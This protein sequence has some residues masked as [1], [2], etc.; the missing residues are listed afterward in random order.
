MAVDVFPRQTWFQ[1]MPKD[2]FKSMVWKYIEV[3]ETKWAITSV[4]AVVQTVTCTDLDTWI[5]VEEY[6]YMTSQG[7][8]IIKRVVFDSRWLSNIYVNC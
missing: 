5:S 3:Y 2:F 6:S 7:V 1:Q 4:K 8:F